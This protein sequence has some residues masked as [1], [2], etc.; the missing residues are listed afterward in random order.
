[1]IGGPPPVV[2]FGTPSNPTA[3]TC[4]PVTST[5][6]GAK[7]ARTTS[8]VSSIRSMRTPARSKS[9]PIASYSF[10]NHPQPSPT[11]SRPSESTSSDA[12]SLAKITGLR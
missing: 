4:S 8:M 10:A 12:S 3:W 9:I 11:S 5:W 1:M 6:P 2:G 7:Q